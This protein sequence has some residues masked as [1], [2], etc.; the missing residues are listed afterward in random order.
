MYSSI[1]ILNWYNNNKQYFYPPICNKLLYKNQITVMFVGI[2][3]FY[4]LF[5]TFI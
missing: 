1:N 2:I 5:F 3:T 4:S